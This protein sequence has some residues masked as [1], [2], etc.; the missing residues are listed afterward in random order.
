MGCVTIKRAE[1][2]RYKPKIK[3]F[4]FQNTNGHNS[5]E[6]G[7]LCADD[8]RCEDFVK[9]FLEAALNFESKI[10]GRKESQL[11]TQFYRFFVSKI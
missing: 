10:S 7:T 9:Q 1:S 11:L 3:S 6:N 4:C 5:S 2:R 8:N